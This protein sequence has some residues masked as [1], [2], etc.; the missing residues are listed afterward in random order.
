MNTNTHP[1]GD[2]LQAYADR[3]LPAPEAEAVAAHCTACDACRQEVAGWRRLQ[4]RLAVDAVTG[5]APRT[6]PAV[7]G[8]LARQRRP[9]GYPF[10]FGA[11]AACAAG[12]ALALFLAGGSAGVH[13]SVDSAAV[14]AAQP[15]EGASLL[16]VYQSMVPEES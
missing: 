3:Q 10:A 13:D 9:L 16:D 14:G 11:V 7:A 6:W 5:P 4:S 8:R 2:V 12:L 15:A 1:R